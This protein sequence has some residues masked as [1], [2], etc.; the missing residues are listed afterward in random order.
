[1]STETSGQTPP[2]AAKRVRQSS[3]QRR[4]AIEATART[5]ALTDGLQN[6]THRSIAKHLGI[7]HTLVVHHAPD[8]GEIRSRA[9]Q[10]LLEEE[11]ATM[12][13]LVAGRSSA[14]GRLS[15]LI[16]A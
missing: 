2:A 16:H 12:E 9:C 13:G 7:T 10:A 15:A 4:A 11:Y 1:M 5:L 14:V 6:L 8:V 3:S